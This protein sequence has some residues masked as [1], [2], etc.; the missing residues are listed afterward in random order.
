MKKLLILG[1][2]LLLT[3]TIYGQWQSVQVAKVLEFQL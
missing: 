3:T 2:A 1:F